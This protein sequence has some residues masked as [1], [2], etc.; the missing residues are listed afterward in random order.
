MKYNTTQYKTCQLSVEHITMQYR[1]TQCKTTQYIVKISS[2]LSKNALV[3]YL[4][5]NYENRLH[6]TLHSISEKK[7]KK[8]AKII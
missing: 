2:L 3:L 5:E 1:T 6:L 7:I 4:K 8:V